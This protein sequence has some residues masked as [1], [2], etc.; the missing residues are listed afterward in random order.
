MICCKGCHTEKNVTF[1]ST[2]GVPMCPSCRD[3]IEMEDDYDYTATIE[4][5]FSRNMSPGS[6][7]EIPEY[8]LRQLPEPVDPLFSFGHSI[9]AN[10]YPLQELGEWEF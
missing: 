8:V 10:H 3:S 6:T 1:D 2:T 7:A 9:R 5:L 4:C